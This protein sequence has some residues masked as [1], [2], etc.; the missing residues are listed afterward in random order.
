MQR[1]NIA[2]D[3]HLLVPLYHG[4]SD[5]FLSSIRQHGLG[6]IDPNAGWRSRELLL[7]LLQ[8]DAQHHFLDPLYRVSAE[9]IS[10]QKVTA[11]GFNF[12]HGSTYLSPCRSTAIRYAIGNPWGSELLSE[13]LKGL[14]QL[15]EHDAGQAAGVLGKYSAIAEVRDQEHEPVLIELSNVRLETLRSEEGKAASETIELMAKSRHV[16]Q[17]ANFEL[18]GSIPARDLTCYRIRWDGKDSLFPDYSLEEIELSRQL[19]PST[20]RRIS[21]GGGDSSVGR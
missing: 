14:D 13:T 15:E 8:I 5:I 6:A 16:W 12:R 2:N 3:T 19:T 1:E 17:Q 18:R 7:E 21:P 20:W 9:P 11:A 10:Q 4:T